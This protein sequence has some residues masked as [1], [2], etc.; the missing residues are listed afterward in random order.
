LGGPILKNRLFVYGAY[1][2]ITNL[3]PRTVSLSMPSLAMR[4][5]DFS[6]LCSSFSSGVCAAGT[7]LYNPFT[8]AP[9]AGNQIPGSLIAHQAKTL[10]PYLPSPTNLPSAALPA[11][12]PNYI[13]KVPNNAH[14]NGVDLRLDGQLS[15]A[16]PVYG[17]IHW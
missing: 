9:F 1:R 7:Q 14:I 11:G 12:S 2:G 10:L 16:D 13:A 3:F 17:V 6:A 5:G 8:G 15:A 4:N